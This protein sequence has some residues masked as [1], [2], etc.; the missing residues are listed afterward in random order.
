MSDAWYKATA[1][2]YACNEHPRQPPELA[3]ELALYTGMSIGNT[4]HLIDRLRHLTTCNAEPETLTLFRLQPG[5]N[6]I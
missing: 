3:D 6:Q 2:N 5:R 1:R 4:R